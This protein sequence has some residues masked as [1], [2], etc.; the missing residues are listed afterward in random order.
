MPTVREVTFNLL[1]KL[2][3]KHFVANPG[4]TEETFL[5]N[6]PKDFNFVMA[7]QEASVVGIADGLSQGLKK[8]VIVNVHTGAGMGNA[9]GCILTARLNKTPLIITAG[10][11]TREML[12]M[13]PFLT[14]REATEFPKPWVKWSYEVMRP[15]D[16]PGTFMRAYAIATQAPAG[17]VFVSIPLDLWDCHI[18][19]VDV[20]R[21]SSVKTAP[22]PEIISSFA[23]RINESINPILIYGGDVA[24]SGAWNEA[25]LLAERLGAP[26]WKGPFSEL[27]SFP[28][29]HGLF[30]GELPSGKGLLSQMLNN[31]D[32]VIV[33]GAPVFRYYPWIPGAYLPKGA[34]LIQI[35]DDPYEAAKSPVGDSLISDSRLA[36][37]CLL[38]E[39]KE[40]HSSMN[41]LTDVKKKRNQA[42]ISPTYP[43][44][45]KQVFDVLS[46]NT[47]DDYVLVEESPSN[48]HEFQESG[49]GTIT[50]PDSFYAMSSGG[51]GWGMPASV[52]LALAEKKSGRKR[53]VILIIGD[54]SFQYS[55]QSIWTAVQHQVHLIIIALRNEEYAILKSFALLEKT[56]NVPGLDLP[57]L[58]LVALAKGYGAEACRADTIEAIENAYQGALKKMGVSVIEIPIDK[59]IHKLLGYI[60]M[61]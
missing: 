52:G 56:P 22:D 9:M 15:E 54:G 5:A 61:K 59:K 28:E 24:R 57:G 17:P 10:Q 30:K 14:N 50:K 47:P 4:S 7:L 19:A 6:F 46:L 12:L 21:T 25:I 26:V 20:F 3:V 1:R 48:S 40:R 37:K 29:D 23:K 58:D 43:L 36:L 49:I 55:V 18:E 42:Q 38:E 2:D 51:L 31:H 8:P 34:S 27:V 45:A 11:Q 33:I 16:V 60:H 32:L 41:F 39:V 53:P 13:E 35:I 44:T